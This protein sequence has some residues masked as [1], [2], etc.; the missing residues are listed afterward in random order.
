[1]HEWTIFIPHTKVYIIRLH[2][3]TKT[4]NKQT[5][6]LNNSYILYAYIILSI[7]STAIVDVVF[8]HLL[9]L[10]TPFTTLTKSYY[11][12]DRRLNNRR[13][14]EHV[15]PRSLYLQR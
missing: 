1:M 10:D 5:L 9:I 14:E 13:K 8:E 2:T 12:I 6:K 7:I 15:I 11:H 4:Y 3:L